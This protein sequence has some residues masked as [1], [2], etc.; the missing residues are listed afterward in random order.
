MAC[1]MQRCRRL[2]AVFGVGGDVFHDSLDAEAVKHTSRFPG[3]RPR[4]ALART[5]CMA[6]PVDAASAVDPVKMHFLQSGEHQR[7]VI[8]DRQVAQQGRVRNSKVF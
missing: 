4:L 6:Y 3:T 5:K 7:F 8:L 1:G 2:L